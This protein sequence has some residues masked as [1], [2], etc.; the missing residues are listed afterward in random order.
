M[1]ESWVSVAQFSDPTS[2]RVASGRL[3]SEK[4]PSAVSRPAFSAELFYLRVPP[5]SVEAAKEILDA[6]ANF[7][8]GELT[9]LAIQE[10]PPDDYVPSTRTE[11]SQT[12]RLSLMMPLGVGVC[13]IFSAG[14][15]IGLLVTLN[16]KGVT[17]PRYCSPAGCRSI[18]IGLI[19]SGL[20]TLFTFVAFLGSLG[21]K[22]GNK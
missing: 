21:G 15:F 6:T 12:R 14:L 7:D 19:I 18:L 4:I 9:R 5:E 20:F 22:T 1:D 3:A 13:F 17:V 8:E 2:A 10:P 11:D 16:R